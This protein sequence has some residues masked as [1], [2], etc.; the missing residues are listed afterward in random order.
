MCK[1]PW[2]GD[3]CDVFSLKKLPL[4]PVVA[5]ILAFSATA[6]L[7]VAVSK[8]NGN[9]RVSR[10]LI[11]EMMAV[12]ALDS[13]ADIITFSATWFTDGFYFAN[14]KNFLYGWVVFL[15]ALFSLVVFIIESANGDFIF[16][17]SYVIVRILLEDG[18]QFFLYTIASL[19][20][21]S[22]D[23]GLP[24]GIMLGVVQGLLFFLGK[25]Y[26]MKLNLFGG[27]NGYSPQVDDAGHA[28][29]GTQKEEQRKLKEELIKAER[30]AADRAEELSIKQAAGRKATPAE[31]LAAEKAEVSVLRLYDT[32][33]YPSPIITSNPSSSL[34]FPCL[35]TPLSTPTP[36]PALPL[37]TALPP[38]LALT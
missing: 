29:N 18:L 23:A 21:F 2:A 37:A 14:D 4:P 35:H 25:L 19:S 10:E 7:G 9:L 27:N 8:V 15:A 31:R 30:A 32:F 11:K 3:A 22:G 12:E 1:P 20:T 33:H 6:A 13:L 5:V 28:A 16:P 17:E 24:V 26:G 36:L 34:P 38:P